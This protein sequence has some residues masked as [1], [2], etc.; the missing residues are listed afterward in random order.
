MTPGDQ[1][2]WSQ[3]E[4]TVV[5]ERSCSAPILY[6]PPLTS[7]RELGILVAHKA[8]G[9]EGGLDRGYCFTFALSSLNQLSTSTTWFG[10][11]ATESA[12]RCSIRNRRPSGETS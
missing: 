9:A 8:E 10:A 6:G 7:I 1:R 4:T 2:R 3:R 5:T 12:M 11:A